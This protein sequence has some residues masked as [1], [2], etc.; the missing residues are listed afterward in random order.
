MHGAV[1][2]Q[3]AEEDKEGRKE[4]ASHDSRLH[5]S[6]H[7]RRDMRYGLTLRAKQLVVHADT[8]AVH[9]LG[10]GAQSL[11]DCLGQRHNALQ[12]RVLTGDQGSGCQGVLQEISNCLD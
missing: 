7:D 2:R 6:G 1:I 3:R 9:L 12:R 5:G 10:R 4:Q 8:F 11:Q